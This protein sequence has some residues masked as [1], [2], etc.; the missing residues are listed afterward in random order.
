MHEFNFKLLASNYDLILIFDCEPRS[1]MPIMRAD[2]STVSL[3]AKIPV[4]GWLQD[5]V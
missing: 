2:M 1:V 3:S 5:G 4:Q